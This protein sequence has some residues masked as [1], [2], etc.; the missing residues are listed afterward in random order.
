ML[1][2]VD[3]FQFRFRM[4]LKL[5]RLKRDRRFSKTRSPGTGWTLP[6]HFEVT[7]LSLFQPS[8]VNARP[9]GVV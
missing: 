8:A 6:Y 7:A 5:H 9:R 4:E 2:C 3:K 1:R